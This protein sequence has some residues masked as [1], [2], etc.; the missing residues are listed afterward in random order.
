MKRNIDLYLEDIRNS[1]RKIHRYI[2]GFSFDDFKKDEKTVD[3][4]V[5]NLEII[6]EAAKNIPKEIK[7][8]YA[9]IPWREIVN[10]SAPSKAL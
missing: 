1:I 9:S 7:T 3:A 8:K 6:G 10:M 2:Q 5:R 4:I